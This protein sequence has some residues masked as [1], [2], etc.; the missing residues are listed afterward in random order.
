MGQNGNDWIW[1][2]DGVHDHVSGGTGY[3][4]YRADKS[5][6]RLRTVEAVM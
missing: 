4:R 2:R 5:I 6:D 1:G 3:D